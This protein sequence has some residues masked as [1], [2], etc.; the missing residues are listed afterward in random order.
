MREHGV[1]FAGKR[2]HEIGVVLRLKVRRLRDGGD[3]E[4]AKVFLWSSNRVG[5]STT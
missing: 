3:W 1:E 5:H 2:Y 4:M